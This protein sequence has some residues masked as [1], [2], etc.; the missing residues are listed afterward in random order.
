QHVVLPVIR[1]PPSSTLFPYTTLFRSDD[2]A[3]KDATRARLTRHPLF[4]RILA[5]LR[6]GEGSV[7]D[8]E[9]LA[10]LTIYFPFIPADSLFQTVVRSVGP[11][12]LVGVGLW[13]LSRRHLGLGA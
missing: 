1:P 13:V 12:R 2:A 9:V 3:R 6:E 4:A 5:M 11:L 10:D 8:E 7:E